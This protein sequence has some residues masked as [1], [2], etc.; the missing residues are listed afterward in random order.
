MKKS[1]F[2]ASILTG[3]PSSSL[4]RGCQGLPTYLL[5]D[6]LPYRPSPTLHP[7]PTLFLILLLHK[8]LGDSF[9]AVYTIKFDRDCDLRERH[10]RSGRVGDTHLDRHDVGPNPSELGSSPAR[11]LE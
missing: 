6:A 11:P 8:F 2:P 7:N 10:R 9:D 3:Q 4:F 1:T 5:R